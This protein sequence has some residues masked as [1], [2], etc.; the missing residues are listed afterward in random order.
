MCLVQR[1]IYSC[2]CS[3][4]LDLINKNRDAVIREDAMAEAKHLPMG[5]EVSEHCSK[6]GRLIKINE[7]CLMHSVALAKFC[8][9]ASPA[10]RCRKSGCDVET[11]RRIASYSSIIICDIFLQGAGTHEQMIAV[12][13]IVKL[14]M[15]SLSPKPAKDMRCSIADR[16]EL[17]NDSGMI[18]WALGNLLQV[19]KTNT[20]NEQ[21]F[22]HMHRIVRT[23]GCK[24][25][26]IGKL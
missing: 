9:A 3:C 13:A 4:D 25:G 1:Y 23:N 19:Q 7:R 2:G 10:S 14:H 18:E 20:T 24:L 15:G 17:S 26:A 12:D 16:A 22:Q 21:V 8:Q 11:H 5:L 6:R